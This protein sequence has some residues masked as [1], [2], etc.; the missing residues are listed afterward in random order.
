MQVPGTS[1]C[2]KSALP[3]FIVTA[4]ITNAACLVNTFLPTSLS[5]RH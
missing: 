4:Y 5:S 2:L 1:V 3:V